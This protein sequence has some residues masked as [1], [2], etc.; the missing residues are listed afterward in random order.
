M[1]AFVFKF[2]TEN[3]SSAEE[4]ESLLAR[5][6][7][8][9]RVVSKYPKLQQGGHVDF[10]V[11]A[12]AQIEQPVLERAHL[13]QQLVGVVFLHFDVARTS[14]AVLQQSQ[15]LLKCK[16]QASVS[17]KTLFSSFSS[18]SSTLF[19]QKA[20]PRSVILSLHHLWVIVKGFRKHPGNVCTSF[21]GY[22]QGSLRRTLF[23]WRYDR[24]HHHVSSANL[25]AK[26]SF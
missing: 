26:H 13:V 21:L 9:K 18:V 3:V 6:K 14:R 12:G 20:T 1:R 7:G 17:I 23:L 4:W 16:S 15:L 5:S 24:L 25:G 2:F 19:T 22:Y 10:L 8:W 11:G